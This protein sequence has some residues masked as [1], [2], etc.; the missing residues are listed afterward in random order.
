MDS[1]LVK[2]LSKL[3]GGDRDEFS[4]TLERAVTPVGSFF[5]GRH[6]FGGRSVFSLRVIRGLYFNFAQR[7]NFR[8][9]NNTDV[10]SASRG[11]EPPTQVLLGIRDR[12][13][14]HRVLIRF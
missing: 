7:D 9:A 12:D 14:L 11:S 5:Q 8:P 3:F 13:S 6:L 10:F 2:R 1:A 4:G